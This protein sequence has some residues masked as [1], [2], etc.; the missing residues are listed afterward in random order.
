MKSS[1]GLGSTIIADCIRPLQSSQS[2]SYS[3]EFGM[4]SGSDLVNTLD[5]GLKGVSVGT[6]SMTDNQQTTQVTNNASMVGSVNG[7]LTVIAGDALHVTGSTVY[8]GNDATFI[9]KSVS[10]DSAFNTMTQSQQQSTSQTAVSGGLTSPI[11]TALQT[12]QAMEKAS[13]DSGDPRLQAMAA[14]TSAMA[15]ANAYT[16]VSGAALGS[17]VG[18]S[19]SLGTSQSNNQ[20]TSTLSQAMGSTASAGNNLSVTATGA[21]ANSNIDVIGS[22]L[23]ATN[24]TTIAADGTVNFLAAK[25][26]TTQ[27]STNDG[28]S[29]NIGVTFGLGASNGV[30]FQLGVSANKGDGNGNDVVYTNTQVSGGNKVALISGSDTN[31]I[32]AVVTAPQVVASVGGNLNIQSLQDT[33]TY[34][35]KQTSAGIGVSLCIPPICYGSSSVSGNFSNAKVNGDYASVTTQSGIQAGD[36]GFQVG[37]AG[38]TNL[39]GAVIASS[40]QAIVDNQ[41]I[42]MTGSLTQSSLQ[43]KDTFDASGFSIAASVSGKVGDQSTAPKGSKYDAANAESKPTGSSGFSSGSGSQA[44]TAQSG[45]SGGLIIVTD[46]AAQVVATGQTADQTIASINRNIVTGADTS[47]ALTKAWNGDQLMQQTQANVQIS[48]AFGSAAAKAIGDYAQKQYD[49]AVKI[50]DAQGAAQWGEGG[51]SRVALQTAAGA[52]G[53]GLNGALGAAASSSIMPIIGD[54]IDKMDLPDPIK[55]ALGAVAASTIGT[56]AGG[57]AGASTAFNVDLNNRQ[58]HNSE[59]VLAKT[60][61]ANSNGKYSIEQI[62]AQM[63]SMTMTENGIVEPGVPTTVIGGA[64]PTVGGPW[65]QIGTTV[66]GQPIYMQRVTPADA[67]LR[68]YIVQYTNHNAVPSLITYAEPSTVPVYSSK[69][70]DI[71]TAACAVTAADCAAGIAPPLS[72]TQIQQRNTQ[73]ADFFSQTS[74]NYTRAASVATA[75]GQPEV[76]VPFEAASAILNLLEQAVRPDIGQVLV[77]SVALDLITKR[78]S[79]QLN[80]PLPVAVEAADRYVKP[81][82]QSARD[83]INQKTMK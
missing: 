70:P 10:F 6:R 2:A 16:A 35:S 60:L 7:N 23:S 55:Q 27:Q 36:L 9:G 28:S 75:A 17:A 32:G 22:R 64:M 49:D 72:I 68:A 51:A 11:I 8:A 81:Q 1:I 25:N 21:G 77:D 57:L 33:S 83:W 14:A 5:G 59:K 71:P 26:T 43:N 76:A 56:M 66:D 45:I 30:S 40:N 65:D 78:V 3:H 62:Q 69:S 80:I 39:T 54:M 19:I 58:L 63:Q 20:S 52:L 13:K 15:V 44:S 46:N 18:V 24:N 67:E 41:N 37:V 4:L 34:D 12:V 82:L 31:L 53:G 79:A 50:G 74:T 61:A 73:L 42:L 47:G 48:A 38:N 29:A